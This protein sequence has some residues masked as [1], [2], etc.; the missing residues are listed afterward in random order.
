[1]IDVREPV[2][3]VTP[4]AGPGRPQV[5]ELVG[6]AATGKTSLLRALGEREPACLAGLRPPRHRHAWSAVTL[7]PTFVGL[8]RSAHAFLWKEM[9]R[10]T[11]LRTL[12][13]SV[14][15]KAAER[16]RAIVMDEGPV[17]MLA[18]MRVYGEA[19]VRSAAF[20]PWWRSAIG[21]W[22]R[23]L[24]L[25]VWLDAPDAILAER[26]RRR[27]Q[28]HRLQGATD[29]TIEGFLGAYRTAYA[30]VMSDLTT[31]PGVRVLA[32]RTDVE[33]A[34]RIA[35]RVVAEL[36]ERGRARP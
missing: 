16:Y 10:I 4:A 27:A 19:R 14:A 25:V 31:L 11:Y 28:H 12:Q 5:V 7:V 36:Q 34:D 32:F 29:R 13:R 22:R 15:A 18:R 35:E 9:K 24:H 1:M 8:H 33:T 17:Y 3:A 23:T 20:E 2:G 26:L 6:L 30:E 21:E